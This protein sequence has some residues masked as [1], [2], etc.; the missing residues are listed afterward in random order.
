MNN[1]QKEYERWLNYQYLHEELLEELKGI[2]DQTKEIEERFYKD[3]EF[4][5]G[6]L[7]GIISAGTNRMNIYTIRKVTLGIARFIIKQG[8]AAMNRG[9]TIA[10]DSRRFSKEFAEEAARVLAKNEIKVYLFDELRPTP[11]LSFAVREL[12]AFSGI[13]I[14]ASH[15]PPEYNGYKV[16]NQYGGQITEEMANALYDE[17]N[18]IENVLEI[19]V[20][21][22]NDAVEQGIVTLIGNE[23]DQKYIKHVET[24]L[25]NKDIV[26]QAGEQ[27]SIVYT[28]LHGTGNKP[29]R[30]ILTH[31]GFKNLHIVKEQELPDTEFSTVKAPNPEEIEVFDLA[32]L[33]AKEKNADIIMATDPD[34]DRLGVLVKANSTYQ[35]LNGNQLGAL[36]LYY[37]LSLMKGRGDLP[38]NAA[39]IKTIVTSELGAK[40]AEANG[41]TTENTLTGFK[42]IG[43]KIREFQEIGSHTFMFGYE[44]SYGYLV[45]DFVR[46]KDAVQMTALVAEMALYYKQKEKTLFDV[47]E[48]IYQAYGYFIEDLFSITLKGIEGSKKISE[49]VSSFR[50]NPPREIGG[51]KVKQYEDYL[52]QEIRDVVM[53]KKTTIDLPK[54]NV[55]KFVLEDES[56]IAMRPSGT[57]PKLKFYFSTVSGSEEQSTMQLQALKKAIFEI[58]EIE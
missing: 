51:I 2:Q 42:Y 6:G 48:E 20:I 21:A 17:I 38:S 46:D 13:M 15:N 33:L 25:L 56:W 9:V 31:L 55:L 24:I 8:K 28:P 23:I 58:A 4:G 18:H 27:I 3:L 1:Y 32:I 19:P 53:E 22:Y 30:N 45:G 39:M 5:T 49:I 47:L 12:H 36:V 57:E 44:E 52:L 43:E 50:N 35:A 40:I 16:Y 29:V 34:A 26:R 14:T 10:Y 7:R 11:L 54:S 37:M 41:V